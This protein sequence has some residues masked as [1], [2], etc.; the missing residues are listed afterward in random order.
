MNKLRA[1]TLGVGALIATAPALAQINPLGPGAFSVP[2]E[3]LGLL[4]AAEEKL[5]DPADKVGTV[6][7]WTNDKTGDSG[8]VTL[9][10][11]FERDGMPCRR[12]AHD[13]KIRGNKTPRQFVL[14]R[15]RV[16][17]GSWKIVP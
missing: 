13:I 9:I 2:R 3:D 15:C 11:T 17:D 7:R 5:Y 14:S 12:V 10:S 6:E 16:A 1:L 4:N 8:T